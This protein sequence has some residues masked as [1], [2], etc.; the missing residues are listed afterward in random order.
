LQANIHAEYSPIQP[1]KLPT[2]LPED[3]KKERATWKE[4]TETQ[5]FVDAA[6]EVEMSALLQLIEAGSGKSHMIEVNGEVEGITA[7]KLKE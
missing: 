1:R 2:R 5:S 4:R 7:K 6:V 3:P